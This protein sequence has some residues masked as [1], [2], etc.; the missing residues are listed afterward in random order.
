MWIW[1][2]AGFL[3]AWTL[4]GLTMI[5]ADILY[6]KKLSNLLNID[7]TFLA[8]LALPAYPLAFIG[9]GFVVLFKL[10]KRWWKK[11]EPKLPRFRKR[12]RPIIK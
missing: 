5:I 2:A 4:I 7:N 12:W 10:A 11:I 3:A 8:I 9:A 1:F 6:Q